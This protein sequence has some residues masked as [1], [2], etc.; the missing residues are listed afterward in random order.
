MGQ[1]L[2]KELNPNNED[3]QMKDRLK[4]NYDAMKDLFSL[5]SEV[6]VNQVFT[7]LSDADVH[8]LGKTRNKSIQKMTENVT[9]QIINSFVIKSFLGYEPI[10]EPPTGDSDP[11]ILIYKISHFYRKN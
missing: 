2:N 11:G 1:S 8:K 10:Q 7:C 9:D 6:I 5:P 3:V 4:K